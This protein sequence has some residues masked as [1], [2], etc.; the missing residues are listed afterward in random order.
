MKEI[1]KYD[2][3]IIGG[4]ASGTALL[5]TLAK[6]SNISSL[7]L[8]EKYGEL[9]SVNSHG[10]NNSQSLHVGDIEMHY[11]REK[12][13]K[14]KPAAM[15]IPEYLK[16]LNTQQSETILKKIQKMALAVGKS[17]V[18][19]MKERFKEFEG[20]F[21]NQRIIERDEI[22]SLEPN[23][24]KDRNP[25]VPILALY[26]PDGHAVNYQALSESFVEEAVNYNRDADVF[27]NHEVTKITKNN[28]TYHI[29]MNNSHVF[30]AQVV[31]VCADSY[32][33]LLA[34][35][36][37][38][39]EEY[40]LVPV[41]A[42]FYYTHEVLKGKV[43]PMQDRKLPFAGVHGDPDILVPN[44][45]RWGPTAKFYPVLE[46]GKWSTMGDY[47]KSASLG[48]WKA[49]KALTKIMFDRTRFLYFLKSA[50]YDIPWIGKRLFVK[51]VKKIVPS[52]SASDLRLGK[53]VGGMRLQRVD[54]HNQSLELGEGK[55]I[56]DNIIFNMTPSPGASVCLYNGM[57]DAETV[58]EML[59]EGYR[60]NKQDMERD[61]I[62]S[63]K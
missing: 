39:G 47:F 7:A 18:E 54:V 43:Y 29:Q 11:T 41:G 45:T 20:L 63:Q 52:I 34:K 21:P 1:K 4:G 61:F 27:L 46:D 56:G 16:T 55:I 25:N 12:A 58:T 37:G 26:N 8:V 38:Y 49:I 32:S 59:G 19:E 28:E 53:G 17:E 6:Y 50:S 14:V 33:L 44:T 31:I 30:Q 42:N 2:V 22:Q 51:N 10:R 3:L 48:R 15:M 36:M 57:R 13:E 5:Y 35:Q 23:I 60:F 40:S 62:L 24:T 9:G